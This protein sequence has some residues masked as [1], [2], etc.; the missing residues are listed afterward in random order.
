ME[1]INY[2]LGY[3]NLKIVQD[4]QMFNFSLDSVLLPNFASVNKRAKKIIDIGCGNCPVSLILTT[5]TTAKLDAIELQEDVFTLATKTVKLNNLGDRINLINADV[6]LWYKYI[7]TDVY[8]LI[9]C[10]PPFFKSGE[11]SLSEYKAT[12]RH[13]ES[14]TTENL[15]MISRKIL[16]NNGLIAMVNRPEHLVEIIELMRENNI[17]PKRM[18]LVYPKKDKPANILLI[19]GCKN[20]KPGLKI[21]E[22][23]YSHNEDGT[24]TEQIKN[25][26]K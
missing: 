9:V 11:K 18:Q 2:L 13:G 16:K 19:E 3:E 14:L 10:N 22:P 21:L 26:F 6:N 4:T 1:Q 12:A 20:G 15:L 17:E 8:D 7:E 5:K 23:I 25:Y 24:Y